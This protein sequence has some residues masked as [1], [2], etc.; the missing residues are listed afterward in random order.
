MKNDPFSLTIYTHVVTKKLH[1]HV[2][3]PHGF[4]TVQ[5]LKTKLLIR[6]L[7]D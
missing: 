3:S 1:D 5:L 2:L 4:F 7:T 6:T